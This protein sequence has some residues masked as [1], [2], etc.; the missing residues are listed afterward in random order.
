[1]AAAGVVK[2]PQAE[3]NA[4]EFPKE[5]ASPRA[6]RDAVDEV[7]L[8]DNKEVRAVGANRFAPFLSPLAHPLF[9]Q[10]NGRPVCHPMHGDPARVTC[11]LVADVF[12]TVRCPAF[13]WPRD[14]PLPAHRPPPRVCASVCCGLC[15][16]N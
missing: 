11:Q 14:A 1:M 13:G 5:F 15:P 8:K 4:D 12:S 6:F 10:C 2:S 3:Q 7:A 16:L 9:D